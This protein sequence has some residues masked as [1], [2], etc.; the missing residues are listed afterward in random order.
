MS[1]GSLSIVQVDILNH[2]GGEVQLT[3]E[4]EWKELVLL[5]IN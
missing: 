3:R 2:P 1:D 4:G 5:R